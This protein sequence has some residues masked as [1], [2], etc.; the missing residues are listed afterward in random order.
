MEILWCPQQRS[1]HGNHRQ[2]RGRP[3]VRTPSIPKL[4]EPHHVGLGGLILRT[5]VQRLPR[6]HSGR[7]TLPHHF[8]YGCEC[9]DQSLSD[10]RGGGGYKTRTIWQISPVEI[11][12]VLLERLAPHLP[13]V[14]TSPGS[15]G[16]SDRSFQPYRIKDR[17]G[18]NGGDYLPA[19]FCGRPTLRGGVQSEDY[20][21]NLVVL[22]PPKE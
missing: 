15:F 20:G 18:T 3:T 7:P 12:F 6:G 11:G 16:C 22:V 4:G 14:G 21:R 2:I 10:G 5:P 13:L 19:V 9:S 17:H 8:Q 1:L